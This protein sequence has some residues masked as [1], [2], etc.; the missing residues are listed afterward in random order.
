MSDP[1]APRSLSPTRRGSYS[2][3]HSRIGSFGDVPIVQTVSDTRDSYTLLSR[4]R[5][6]DGDLSYLAPRTNLDHTVETTGSHR[7]SHSHQGVPLVL[8]TNHDP[9]SY[10]TRYQEP[11]Q[12]ER[13]EST[14]GQK[15]R[16]RP[17]P[18][19][20]ARAY[21]HGRLSVSSMREDRSDL[22][23]N[24]TRQARSGAEAASTHLVSLTFALTSP[25]CPFFG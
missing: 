4:S 2:G 18:L 5:L 14:G 3:D 6:P 11:A 8:V 19:S 10:R 13:A 12:R 23:S 25:P 9:N 1:R 16:I 21:S 7:R 24:H 15:N 17:R 22:L 20:T